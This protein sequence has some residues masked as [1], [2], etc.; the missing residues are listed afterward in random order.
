MLLSLFLLVFQ[1]D[2]MK[3][4][5]TPRLKGETK[6]SG[7]DSKDA[8]QTTHNLKAPLEC[9]PPSPWDLSH[10][11]SFFLPLWEFNLPRPMT[12]VEHTPGN[13]PKRP[14][15]KESLYSFLVKVSGCKV[16]SET[17][18]FRLRR[19]KQKNKLQQI[20]ERPTQTVG[21]F[22]SLKTSPPSIP[23]MTNPQRYQR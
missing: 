9:N 22:P 17:R 16:F 19:K 11:Y 14:L 4:D 8:S 10:R 20:T 18:G 12:P 5:E 13:P 1:V 23:K 7:K 21:C 15:W 2:G 3:M 6:P